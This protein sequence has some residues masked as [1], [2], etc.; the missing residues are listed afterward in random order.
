VAGGEDDAVGQRRGVVAGE[1]ARLGGHDPAAVGLEHQ[2]DAT[3]QTPHA[4]ILVLVFVVLRGLYSA[5]EGGVKP[6]TN[7]ATS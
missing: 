6:C 7:P 2:C 5:D 1:R 4:S 3:I